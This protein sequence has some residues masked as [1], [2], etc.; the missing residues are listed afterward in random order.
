MIPEGSGEDEGEGAKEEGGVFLFV[1]LVS[2]SVGWLV[3]SR[4]GKG[5]GTEKRK[6][7]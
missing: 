7:V 4:E 1:W 3:G 2:W 6:K 5:R